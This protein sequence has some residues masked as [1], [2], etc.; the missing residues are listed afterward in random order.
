MSAGFKSKPPQARTFHRPSADVTAVTRQ[1]RTVAVQDL[2][3]G[4]LVAH[5]G[6]V[7]S[8]KTTPKDAKIAL[9]VGNPM[10]KTFFMNYGDRLFA[11]VEKEPE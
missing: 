9:E 8:V 3:P 4:D 6:L 7:I 1:W 10:S 11:F 5:R 2:K